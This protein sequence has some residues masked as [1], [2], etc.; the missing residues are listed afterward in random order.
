[1]AYEIKLEAF[2]GP[3]DLLI[4]LININEIEVHDIP[5]HQI[6]MQYLEYLD[7]MQDLDMDI[8]SEFLVMAATLIEIKSKML[9]PSRDDEDYQTMFDLGDP[10]ADLVMKLVEYKKYKNVA[11][12]F[13]GREKEFGK[14]ILKDQ[15]DLEPFVKKYTNEELNSGL[16]SDLLIEAVK[17]ILNNVNKEDQGRK[18]FFQSLKRDA[19]TV[20]QK[21]DLIRDRILSSERIYFETL[22]AEDYIKSE[23]IVTFL[24]IL[25]LLKLKTVKIKQDKLFDR[26]EIYRNNHLESETIGA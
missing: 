24:A 2:E 25:E 26:I 20:E 16:E 21:M 6:T 13:K 5:I 18:G 11:S 7:A 23:V 8:A 15:E 12:F 22:F 17:R 10:R 19:Y 4:H 9:L 3:F 14:T 1:M